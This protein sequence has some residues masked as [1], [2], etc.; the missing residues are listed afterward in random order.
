M[1][2]L[3]VTYL[4]GLIFLLEIYQTF[5]VYPDSVYGGTVNKASHWKYM[6][7]PQSSPY[8]TA[9]LNL[10]L[11]IASFLSLQNQTM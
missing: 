10:K 4:H 9:W 11:L 8:V 6:T 5:F 3:I 1:N 2:F 7:F